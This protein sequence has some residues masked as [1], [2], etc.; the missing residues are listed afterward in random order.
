MK[1]RYTDV[2]Y[3]ANVAEP[4]VALDVWTIVPCVGAT[5]CGH[6]SANGVGCVREL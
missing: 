1:Y 3:Q 2:S 6:S 4:P 5:I